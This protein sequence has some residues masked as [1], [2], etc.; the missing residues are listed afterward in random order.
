MFD[1]FGTSVNTG[2]ERLASSG[3]SGNLFFGL[4]TRPRLVL[5]A[6]ISDFAIIVIIAMMMIR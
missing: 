2:R 6:Q 1:H 3:A 4:L 5:A